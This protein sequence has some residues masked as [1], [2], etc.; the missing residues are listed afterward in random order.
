MK[1]ASQLFS[2][3]DRQAIEAAVAAAEE[4]T[5]AEIIPVVA[6][7][8]GRY[9]RAEDLFG[10]IVALVALTVAWLGFQDLR[11][12]SSWASGPAP[13]L[14]LIPLLLI[15]VVGFLV[16]AV[17][18]TRVPALRLPF[19]TRREMRDSV[20]Q[21]AGQAF[22]RFRVRKTADSTGILIY[23]S[24]YERMVRVLGDDAI[25]AKL[26][27]EDWNRA[28]DLIVDGLKRGQPAEGLIQAIEECGKLCAP[29]FPVRSDDRNELSN[30]LRIID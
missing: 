10:V 12:P 30:E 17:V 3:S 9:D 20:E 2:D 27:Q 14:G 21:A 18:A 5:S 19:I 11:A 28:R 7:A 4:R 1:R 16:G 15:V 22:H 24:L 23:I 13:I 6:T 26:T 29:H 25:A 8:S